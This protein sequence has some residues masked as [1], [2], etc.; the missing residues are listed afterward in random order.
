LAVCS[1]RQSRPAYKSP[2]PSGSAP[3]RPACPLSLTRSRLFNSVAVLSLT[4]SVVYDPVV[5]AGGDFPTIITSVRGPH[6][7]ERCSGPVYDS[8][9][10]RPDGLLRVVD[11][12]REHVDANA[13]IPGV[14]RAACSVSPLRWLQKPIVEW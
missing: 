8:A 5:L 13:G 7:P 1:T 4:A 9:P 10:T 11:A 14:Q 3:A 6:V 12:P 2:P